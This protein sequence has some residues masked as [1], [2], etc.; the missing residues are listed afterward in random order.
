MQFRDDVQCFSYSHGCFYL[1]KILASFRNTRH[2]YAGNASR[3]QSEEARLEWTTTG[4]SLMTTVCTVFDDD[5]LL[6][7]ES[8]LTTGKCE[9]N[10]SSWEA[11][12]LK[13]CSSCKRKRWNAYFAKRQKTCLY[14]LETKRLNRKRS[15][16][17]PL[18][19]L[20]DVA[21]RFTPRLSQEG[22]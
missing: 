14:C 16:L 13:M 5:F 22:R 10:G 11:Y 17:T 19:H 7:R 6:L 18:N 4:L 21:D 15:G 8:E 20:K 3:R 12:Q 2:M 9:E 1:V